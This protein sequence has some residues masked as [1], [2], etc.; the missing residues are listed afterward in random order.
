MDLSKD[1]CYTAVVKFGLQT[2]T[3]DSFGNITKIDKNINVTQQMILSVMGDFVG[4]ISQ[5]PP[6][7]SALKVG[8]KKAY[9]LAR[10]G[11]EFELKPFLTN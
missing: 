4:E 5:Y 10:E 9:E 2:D 6:K 1:K 8:G 7:F 11:V 3:L